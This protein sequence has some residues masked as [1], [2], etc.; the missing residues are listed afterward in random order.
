MPEYGDVKFLVDCLLL[1]NK[2][3]MNNTPSVEKAI[4][5]VFVFNGCHLTLT[6]VNPLTTIQRF[7]SSSKGRTGNT[8][9]HPR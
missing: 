7:A 2:F 1:Q 5:I 3:V 6:P 8:M 9:I 4:I